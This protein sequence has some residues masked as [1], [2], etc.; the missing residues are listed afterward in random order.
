MNEVEP[1]PAHEALAKLE[2]EIDDLTLITQN[3]DDLHERGGSNTV[4]HM[5]GRLQT[6]RCES[7]G[8]IEHRMADSDLNDDFVNCNCCAEPSRMR[9]DIV[10]FGE[11]PMEMEQ[12]YSAVE[13]CDVF[14]V[15]GSSGHVYPAAGMVHVARSIGAHTIL[16][17]Y[18]MPANGEDF[19]EVH[20]GKAGE[21]LP[22][23]VESWLTK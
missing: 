20:L 23:L 10:W 15:V 22:S 14:I 3:V 8:Q 18:E 12:I 4:I 5:H 2:S 7:S 13:S 17:N 19:D 9:P 1:N 11:I 21:V 16:V 6:L